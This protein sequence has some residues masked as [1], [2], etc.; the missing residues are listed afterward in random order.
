MSPEMMQLVSRMLLE[1]SAMTYCYRDTVEGCYITYI[2][3]AHYDKPK[4]SKDEVI[5]YVLDRL[6]YLTNGDTE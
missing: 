3:R 1:L 6:N 5:D 4:E 2:E